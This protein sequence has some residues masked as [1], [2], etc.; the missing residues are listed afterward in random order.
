MI[1]EIQAGRC[2]KAVLSAHRCAFP[3]GRQLFKYDLSADEI[4]TLK[5]TLAEAFRAHLPETPRLLG[6]AF[7][8][9]AAHWFQREFSGGHWSWSGAMDV[10]R[11]A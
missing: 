5:N 2:L 1:N 4:A 3:D 9:W 10:S 7:C 11:S 8:L 6:A